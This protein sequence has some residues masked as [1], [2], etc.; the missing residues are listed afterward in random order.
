ML[1]NVVV[2]YS[3]QAELALYCQ[4][5]QFAA[6]NRSYATK[7]LA[8]HVCVVEVFISTIKYPLVIIENLALAAM[9]VFGSVWFD[10]CKVSD[11]HKNLQNVGVLLI[12]SPLMILLAPVH[13]FGRI[14]VVVPNA[15]NATPS[16]REALEQAECAAISIGNTDRQVADLSICDVVS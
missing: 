3:A 10:C 8:V 9:N 11:A 1:S 4:L 7:W 6:T 12:A 5:N 14:C 15:Q 2:K 13:L 16:N